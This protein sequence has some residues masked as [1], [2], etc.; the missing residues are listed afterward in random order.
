M[1][2]LRSLAFN[3]L[4]YAWTAAIVLFG[5]PALAVGRRG[6]YFVGRLWA[7]GT[8]A[9]LAA[10]VGIR[11]RILGRERLPPEPVIAAVK[12]QSSWDTMTCALL[13]AEPA[14]VLKRELTWIPLFGW[15]LL[16]AEMI[17][18]DRGAGA[19]AMR[20]LLRQA[21]IAAPALGWASSFASHSG[22]DRAKNH[23]ARI[24]KGV[25]GSSGRK[26]PMT[27]SATDST[28]SAR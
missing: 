9:L 13:F 20:K 17:A 1:A 18:L 25:V 7:R 14:Y 24:R 8:F 5:L 10:L 23:A 3:I 22:W 6:V 16:R 15:Y 26:A 27:P 12:H 21:R 19:A 28:P 2:W 4:F 11:H